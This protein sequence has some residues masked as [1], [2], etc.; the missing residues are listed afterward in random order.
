[1]TNSVQS[2]SPLAF[3]SVYSELCIYFLTILAGIPRGQGIKLYL[4]TKWN[5]KIR[6][7]IWWGEKTHHVLKKPDLVLQLLFLRHESNSRFS[8]P[9]AENLPNCLREL[10]GPKLETNEDCGSLQTTTTKVYTMQNVYSSIYKKHWQVRNR[11]P[12]L[13]GLQTKEKPEGNK[14]NPNL[15]I[16]K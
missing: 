8:L 2:L 3:H 14:T 11:I 6:K 1:M 15:Q 9:V 12:G 4:N 13:R 7:I 16:R 10:A 5:Q